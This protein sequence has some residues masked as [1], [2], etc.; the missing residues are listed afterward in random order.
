MEHTEIESGA[1]KAVSQLSEQMAQAAE[2]HRAFLT[3]ITTFTK[4]ESLRFVNLRID[5]NSQALNKMQ[6]A[7]GLAG[8]IGVQQE[9]LREL[10][11]DYAE[12]GQRTAQAY[13]G[14]AQTVAAKATDAA[15]Q[16]VDRAHAKAQDTLHQSAQAVADAQN[17]V[18]AAVQNAGEQANNFAQDAN[19]NWQH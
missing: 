8:L 4:D 10:M 5:R 9:W 2:S 14:V 7:Q 18:Q 1:A 19:N 3:E 11:Q 16:A 6:S 12:F 13:R 15:S 17:H